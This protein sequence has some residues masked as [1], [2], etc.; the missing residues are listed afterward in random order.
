MGHFLNYDKPGIVGRDAA[1]ADKEQGPN[2]KLVMLEVEATSSDATGFEPVYLAD[3]V[4][5]FVTS[6]GYGHRTGQ[7]LALA[8][9]NT[10]AIDPEAQYQ[11]P[12]IGERHDARLLSEI[13]F[14]ASGSRMRG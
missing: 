14:D 7:S 2:K 12:L 8:Y 3:Q 10:D 13:P 4:V 9:V 11:I 1:L 5:G 6:G